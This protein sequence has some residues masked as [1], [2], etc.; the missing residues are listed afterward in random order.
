MALYGDSL[1][2]SIVAASLEGRTGLRVLPANRLGTIRA[3]VA[4]FDLA[5][6]DPE[7]SAVLRK[8]DHALVC[9]G[10]DLAAE[11]ALVFFGRSSRML[12]TQDL[13]E[14]ITKGYAPCTTI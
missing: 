2:L 3:D 7:L 10:V 9:I 5:A 8:A 4:V 6:A 11:H 14:A 12:T 13:V 1:A